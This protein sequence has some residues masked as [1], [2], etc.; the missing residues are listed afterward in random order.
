METIAVFTTPS[1]R[2]PQ[3]VQ[4]RAVWPEWLVA[5]QARGTPSAVFLVNDTRGRMRV[6]GESV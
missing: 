4:V 6:T 3:P 5:A 2:S 1:D